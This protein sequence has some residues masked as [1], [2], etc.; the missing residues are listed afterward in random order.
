MCVGD[1]YLRRLR[2]PTRSIESRVQNEAGG[3]PD[4]RRHN[5]N[6]AVL[7]ELAI[8]MLTRRTPDSSQVKGFIRSRANRRSERPSS[9]EGHEG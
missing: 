8:L 4:R 1:A 2:I 7:L 3:R 6:P 9:P 5:S